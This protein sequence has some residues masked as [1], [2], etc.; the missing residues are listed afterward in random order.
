MSSTQRAGEERGYSACSLVDAA[1]DDPEALSRSD[2]FHVL[3]AWR[4]RETLR[5]L[6]ERDGETTLGDLADHIA[7]CETEGPVGSTERKRVYV[8]LYQCHLPK[9]DDLD[10]VAFEQARGTVSIGPE[11]DRLRPYLYPESDG[12][13]G[14][15][16]RT[17]AAVG[18]LVGG[19]VAVGAQVL[20][21]VPAVLVVVLGL[22][23]GGLFAVGVGDRTVSVGPAERAVGG[24]AERGEGA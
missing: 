21:P 11:F 16:A 14:Y 4:R 12:E 17:L 6:L 19:A 8:S 18:G 13:D 15:D 7:A 24:V 1:E 2:V 23:F 10:I 5:V 22:T 9:L 3:Q 20:L